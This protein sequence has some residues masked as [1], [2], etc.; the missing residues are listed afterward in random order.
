MNTDLVV[1]KI[2]G[3]TVSPKN[4]FRTVDQDV[5]HEIAITIRELL[6]NNVKVI[7]VHGGGAHAHTPSRCYGVTKSM[8]KDNLIGLSLTKILLKELE[9]EVCKILL[10]HGITVLPFDT[11]SLLRRSD[12]GLEIDLYVVEEALRGGYVP[13]LHGDI[14]SIDGRPYIISSDD[15]MYIL[16]NRFKPRLAIFIMREGGI[17]GRDGTIIRLLKRSDVVNLGEVRDDKYVDVTGGLMR[18]LDICFKIANIC[19]VYI[20]PCRSDILLDLVLY[21]RCSDCTKIVLDT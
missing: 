21:S 7:L 11:C 3:N 1:F 2:G 20:C 14:T 9:I 5:V 15:L 17:L 18:K 10:Q 4:I 6:K 16:V 13:V 19:D 12:N 8:D